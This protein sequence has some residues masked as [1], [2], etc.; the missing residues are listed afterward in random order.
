[1][2]DGTVIL[3]SLAV[4]LGVAVLALLGLWRRRRPPDRPDTEPSSEIRELKAGRV[5]SGWYWVLVVVLVVF[6]FLTGFSI[7]IPFLVAGLT[8]AVMAPYRR[9]PAVFWPP[10]VAV[11]ALIAGFVAVAPLGCSTTASS[12]VLG[13]ATGGHTT[14]NNLVG[15]DYSGSGSYSPSLGPALSAG[16]I[17]AVVLGSLSRLWLRHRQDADFKPASASSEND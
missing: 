1:M 12:S 6:G 14:C 4:V 17:T 11:L 10:V 7:G 9:R 3:A 13:Q 15:I 16:V 5:R 2:Y 8:M